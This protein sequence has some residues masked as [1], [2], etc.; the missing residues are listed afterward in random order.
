MKLSSNS[1]RYFNPI[2]GQTPPVFPDQLQFKRQGAPADQER[3][4]GAGPGRGPRPLR[5]TGS[6]NVGSEGTSEDPSPTRGP[7]PGLPAALHGSLYPVFLSTNLAGRFCA[8]PPRPGGAAPAAPSTS[9]NGARN[10]RQLSAS[11]RISADHCTQTSSEAEAPSARCSVTTWGHRSRSPP[12]A[13]DGPCP[14]AAQR[15]RA[16]CA[17]RGAVTPTASRLQAAAAARATSL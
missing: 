4:L 6:Q 2:S 8:K 13:L 1:G 17:Q 11:D 10:T 15:T 3:P 5:I 9:A 14:R 12:G 7:D 16:A